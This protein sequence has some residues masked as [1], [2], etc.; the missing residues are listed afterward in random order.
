M[1]TQKQYKLSF[2]ILFEKLTAQFQRNLYTNTP[3]PS[4]KK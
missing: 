3:I 2:E 4:Y 1:K